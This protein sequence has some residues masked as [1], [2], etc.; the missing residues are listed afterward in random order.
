MFVQLYILPIVQENEV[1]FP[2]GRFFAC[3]EIKKNPEIFSHELRIE[4]ERL[5]LVAQVWKEFK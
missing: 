1:N 5:Q 4:C 3:E 2:G